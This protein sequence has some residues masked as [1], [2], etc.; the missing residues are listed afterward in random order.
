[1]E[2]RTNLAFLLAPQQNALSF[3]RK[4]EREFLLLNAEFTDISHDIKERIDLV[5]LIL[6]LTNE[7]HDQ[8]A[9][10]QVKR[11][12]VGVELKQLRAKS[13]RVNLML[14]DEL[15]ASFAASMPSMRRKQTTKVVP[16]P[17][18]AEATV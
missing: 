9:S 15:F 14:A 17:E 4:I 12:K 8:L 6:P 3:E 7:S 13:R 10:L 2:T 16:H 5:R 18:S 1:M 11:T